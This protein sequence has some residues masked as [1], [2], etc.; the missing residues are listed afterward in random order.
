VNIL[1]EDSDYR[2]QFQRLWIVESLEAGLFELAVSY[3]I[4]LNWLTH[5]LQC[6]VSEFQ[7]PSSYSLDEYDHFFIDE[8]HFL[9]LDC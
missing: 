6:G 2:A 7:R 4:V 8:G 3:G 5:G 1:G 9:A